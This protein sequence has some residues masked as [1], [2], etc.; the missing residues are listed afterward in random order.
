[1][2]L[3]HVA[4][5]IAGSLAHRRNLAAT[6]SAGYRRGAGSPVARPRPAWSPGCALMAAALGFW[7]WSATTGDSGHD[8]K[9]D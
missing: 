6:M 4:G 5:V 7:T 2:F 8:E 3:V 9:D 1:M